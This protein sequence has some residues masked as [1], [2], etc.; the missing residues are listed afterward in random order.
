MT[1]APHD[2]RARRPHGPGDA[3]VEG[4]EGRF[5]GRF[6]AAGLL[7]AH[8]RDGVLLQ[9]RAEW[10]HLGGTWGIP[11]G[12]V[13]DEQESAV[14]AALREAEEEA[15]VPAEH[16]RVLG[17]S[18]LDFGF[19]S[20]TTVLARATREVVP[21]I[22]DAESLELRWVD[23]AEVGTLSLHPGLADAWPML[24]V[25]LAELDPE[26]STAA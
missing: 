8:P 18:V 16:V 20:Y 3:W 7:L 1:R 9:L 25:R 2:P 15:G 12:A 6:G 14:A 4:P 19:W 23:F 5:W 11:G 24:R 10:S 21:V 13:H 17:T 26:L 22:G